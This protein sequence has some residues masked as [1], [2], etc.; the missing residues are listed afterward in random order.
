MK[1]I[2]GL[3]LLATWMVMLAMPAEAQMRFGVKGGVNISTISFDSEIISG[4]NITG[5]HIGPTIE[6]TVPIF[7]LGFDAAILYSQKGVKITTELETKDFH[8]DHLDIPINLKWKFGL[9]I[10]KVYAAAGPYFDIRLGGDK[11]WNVVNKT[12]K[13][14]TFG[15]GLNFGAGVEVFK[16]LQVGFNY[17]LGLTDNYSLQPITGTGSSVSDGKNRGWSIAAAVYF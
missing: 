7:G 10:F 12:L 8:T 4:D 9:P 1:K 5:F 17:G 15:M 11:V 13:T 2:T 16:Y 6:A 3:V 14:K